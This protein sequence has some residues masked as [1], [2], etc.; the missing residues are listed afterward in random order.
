MSGE[1]FETAI[2]RLQHFASRRVGS[3]EIPLLRAPEGVR[4]LRLARSE[5]TE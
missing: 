5:V 3:L 1:Y 4:G 2:Q